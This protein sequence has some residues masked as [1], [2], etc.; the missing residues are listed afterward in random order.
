MKTM[1]NR[2]LPFLLILL[3]T[4]SPALAEDEA[5]DMSS[6]GLFRPVDCGLSAQE[7][8]EFPFI[9]L[10]I[11]LP[12]E[13]LT[14]MES[15]DIFVFPLEDYTAAGSIAYAMLRF[16]APTPAEKEAEGFSVDIF[17]YEEAMAKVGVI[18][19]YRKGMAGQLDALTLCDQHVRV[20]ESADGAYEYYLST[21]SSG[22]ADD[23]ALLEAAKLTIVEMHALDLSLGYSA[24]SADR[25]DGIA[26][27]GTFTA[28]DIFGQEYTQEI[29][30]AYDL[31]LVNLFATWC[32]P[33]VEELPVLEQLRQS[34]AEKGIRLGVIA[35][36]MDAKTADGVDE[37]AVAEA[38]SLAES[39]G[40]DY[41]FLIPAETDMN[42]RL[43]G[44]S[45]FPE[46]FFV[47]SMGNIVSEPSIGANDLT[48]WT[49]IV[50][51]VLDS[52][53]Y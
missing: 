13:L 26:T 35:V 29:F 30:Q 21:N 37:Y 39:S 5:V 27:V 50:E 52:I 14:L 15:R 45:A 32:G 20:G 3:L 51:Q 6:A 44:I 7:A 31:T 25:I 4:F 40:A 12:A 33:C 8:Y 47:D 46:S 34:C 36:V 38:Q 43:T 19:L 49:E 53:G 24:F 16:S 42:G 18:G 10:H 2:I 22:D 23:T 11:Q 1:L 28:R 48:G 41:P 9:G 17:A